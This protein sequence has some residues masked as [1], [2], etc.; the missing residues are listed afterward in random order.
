MYSL[1]NLNIFN[2]NN[3]LNQIQKKKMD[4]VELFRKFLSSFIVFRQFFQIFL[5]NYFSKT[6]ILSNLLP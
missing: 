4:F 3:F 6:Q 2:Y 5:E 1:Q